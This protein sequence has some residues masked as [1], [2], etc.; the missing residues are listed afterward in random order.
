MSKEEHRIFHNGETMDE[1]ESSLVFFV[2]GKKVVEDNIDPSWTLL[3]YLRTKLRLCGTKLGCA[4]GGCG[5]CTVMVSKYHRAEDKVRHIPVN[6]CLAPVCSM[7]GLAVTT[8]EGIGSVK[9][10]LH[11][12]QERIAKS[13]GSQCGF[14][15]PGI[16]M[17]MYTL[18]RNMPKPSMEDLEVTFQGNLCRCTGY[19]PIIEAYK[20]FTEDWEKM[21]ASKLTN[22]NGCGMGKDCCMLKD[23]KVELYSESEFVPYHESQEPIFPPELK[24]KDQWDKQ[25]LHFKSKEISWF[26]P[27]NLMDLLKLKSKFPKA[28]IVVGNTEIG[29]ETKFKHLTYPVLIQPSQIT[30]LEVLDITDEGL[31]VGAAVTLEALNECLK[32]QMKIL[33]EWKTRVF[34]ALVETLHYFGGKQTRSVACVGGNIITAS[35]ISDLNPIFMVAKIE[36]ELQSVDG[37]RRV[38]MDQNFFTGYRKTILNEDEILIGILL[39]FSEEYQYIHAHKQSRRR[40]DDIAIVNAAINVKF[41]EDS[42]KLKDISM[43]FGGLAPTTKLITNFSEVLGMEWLEDVLDKVYEVIM[44]ELVLDSE[45]PG[46]MIAYRRALPLSFFLKTF[47]ALKKEL[48]MHE[49]DSRD[50]SAFKKLS[51]QTPKSSQVFQLVPEDQKDIDLVGR[52]INHVAAEMQA[53]GEAIYFDDI[54]KIENEAY[55]AYVYST[56]AFANIISIDA[57]EALA[58]DGVVGFIS[59]KDIKIGCNKFGPVVQDEEVFITKQVT[60]QYQ[61]LGAIVANDQQIAQKAARKVAVDYEELHPVIVSIEDAIKHNSF[62]DKERKIECGDVDG[63]F[64]TTRNIIKSNCRTGYQEHFYLETHGC[65]VVPKEV[66]DLEIYTSSQHHAEIT[67][68][69]SRILN[70]PQN[71]IVTKI[72]RIGGG[73]GGKQSRGV[74]IAVTAAIAANKF[75]RPIRIMLDR[76]EDMA[77][78]G[79]RHPFFTKYKVAFN[80]YGKILAIDAELYA[81]AGCSLDLSLE[82][83]ERA[84]LHIENAYKIENLRVIGKICRTNLPSNTAFRGFGAPQAMLAAETMIRNISEFVGKDPV[85]IAMKNLYR[86]GDK[87]HY[88]QDMIN[89]NLTRCLEQCVD[90]SNYHERKLSVQKFN[91]E[92]RWKKRGISVVCTKYGVGFGV[93]FLEQAGALV[94]V[95]TDGS[96]LLTHSG[97]EMG[98]GL[99]TKMIQVASRVLKIPADM[100]YISEVSTDKVPNSSPSAASVGSDLNGVA[101]KKACEEIR[102]RL[103]PIINK[104]PKGEWKEWIKDAYFNRISLSATGYHY[105]P[106]I[107]YDWDTNTG[108]PYNYFTYGV[109]CTE[110]EV[111]CLTGDHQLLRTDI[112]MDLGASL[113]PAIDIGQIEGAFMQG[114]GLFTLEE[115][116]YSPSGTVLSKGPGS[117]KIPGFGDIPI[118]FNVSLLEGVGNPKAVYSSKAVGEPPLFLASSALFAIREAMKSAR[119]GQYM[120]PYFRLHAPATAEKIRMLCDDHITERIKKCE[121]T[122]NVIP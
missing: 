91:K 14:C 21:R 93:P 67:D 109:A 50:L 106:E 10:K 64:E 35:P 83:M 97:V 5:A 43:A 49:V 46:G 62:Y 107:T 116:V 12:V 66:D 7:H 13:H 74:P 111:D 33:P 118:E 55:M 94:N 78:T 24:L 90:S 96:V 36:L 40:D 11:P 4:E 53:T 120:P 57:S 68:L 18:L 89:C 114:Y 41:D 84:V 103:K 28:K 79:G 73:F 108:T 122:W 19:R 117:Y 72:K 85:D 38:L 52:P 20:T 47:I 31:K 110:V 115:M 34:K 29:I 48:N 6:A 63:V 2:N 65:L 76:D 22:G 81:N 87:T 37:S 51:F 75:R 59:A 82:V 98:Q 39:P 25:S 3:Q 60:C 23:R 121:N 61:M 92:N 80:D 113:N 58:M 86:E 105:T 32:E 44:R 16:V 99:N 30:E 8:V 112:V 42:K 26:R 104:N 95:Y 1:Y 70:I 77:S 119:L 101:V 27:T 71:R 100:I 17:S 56:K 9:T 45:A 102:M 69:V 15:T 54:P 88:N